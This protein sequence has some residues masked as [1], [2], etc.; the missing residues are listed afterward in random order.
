MQTPFD[1]GR[2]AARLGKTRKSNPFDSPDRQQNGA[3]TW[4]R[5]ASEW[6]EGYD[7]F[8]AIQEAEIRSDR[9]RN[10]AIARWHK[11]K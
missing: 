7:S 5:K 3:V 2:S 11:N 10:A 9:A 1:A 4:E 8:N 6:D